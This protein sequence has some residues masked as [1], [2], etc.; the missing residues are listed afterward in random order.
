M[1]NHQEV[2]RIVQSIY[3]KRKEKK[4]VVPLYPMEAFVED[5]L[6]GV[7]N[8]DLN[9]AFDKAHERCNEFVRQAMA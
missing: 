9:M 8:G 4:K 2:T 5:A 3:D 7:R 6:N 1:T